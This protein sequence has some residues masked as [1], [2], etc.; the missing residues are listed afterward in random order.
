[1]IHQP[2]NETKTLPAND[3]IRSFLARHKPHFRKRLFI[4]EML[5]MGYPGLTIK[6]ARLIA[7]E[8]N[9]EF[10]KIKPPN[11]FADTI[12][13]EIIEQKMADL[14]IA[15]TGK[16]FTKQNTP[17][18]TDSLSEDILS[19]LFKVRQSEQG[20]QILLSH[21]NTKRAELKININGEQLWQSARDIAKKDSYYEPQANI[22]ERAHTFY[23]LIADGL[24]L[25]N[26]SLINF[27][28]LTEN[29]MGALITLPAPNSLEEGFETL[30]NLDY[31]NK[32]QTS[33]GISLR[34]LSFEDSK[35]FLNLFETTIKN[36][37]TCNNR[38]VIRVDHPFIDEFINFISS[39]HIAKS[40]SILIELPE[41]FLEAVVQ[42]SSF[43]LNN[44]Q[45]LPARSVFKR[46]TSELPNSHDFGFFFCDAPQNYFWKELPSMGFSGLGA[47]ILLPQTEGLSGHINLSAVAFEGNINWE[48]LRTTTETAVHFLDNIRD[49]SKKSG[50]KIQPCLSLGVTGWAHLLEQLNIPYNSERA[51]Y[52]AEKTASFINGAAH[53]KSNQLLTLRGPLREYTSK[54]RHIC[55][56]GQTGTNFINDWINTTPGLM[57]RKKVPLSAIV[58]TLLAFQKNWDNIFFEPLPKNIPEKELMKLI[59]LAHQKKMSALFFG[60][61]S[62]NT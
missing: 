55:L 38:L 28:P 33:C 26:H 9:Q 53:E 1:M 39:P 42:N 20:P 27:D 6:L 25:P 45:S 37:P 3:R 44:G 40:T 29:K 13:F 15:Q 57:P 10:K 54:T 31:Y 8:V 18:A 35:S 14:G 50:L 46:L 23:N 5:A 52:L 24:F 30:K 32:N 43:E 48:K 4:K 19:K 60:T 51:F 17:P 12:L 11:A 34:H 2:K 49:L 56:T 61:Y 21:K 58:E 22:E 47:Q 7:L 59:L 16:I 36:S 62:F 41:I